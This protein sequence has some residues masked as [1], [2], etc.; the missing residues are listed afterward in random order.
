M[1]NFVTSITAKVQLFV[2]AVG[3]VVIFSQAAFAADLPK[4]D[5]LRILI[6]SDQVNPHGLPPEDL[7]QPGDISAALQMPG[8]GL[9]ISKEPDSILEIPTNSIEMATKALGVSLCSPNAYDVL[10]YFCH[11]IPNNGSAK[12][13]TA[14]QEAFVDAVENYLIA[15]GGMISFHHGS[16]KTS[17]KDSIQSIIGATAVASVVWDT[18]DGQN[19]INVSPEHFVTN[20]SVEYTDQVIY[21]DPDSGV[22]MSKYEFF[23][24]TPDERYLFFDINNDIDEF[25][26]LFASNY[27]Q[28]GTTH[29][30]GF[31]HKRPEWNGIV[32]GYQPGEYQPNALDDLDGN[33][34]Q[35]LANAIYYVS[36]FAT[37]CA[38]FNGDGIVDEADLKY[39]LNSWGQ[40]S[41]KG[42]C[43]L[44]DING[45]GTVS[46]QDLLDLLFSWGD[47]G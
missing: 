43:C 36:N 28:I 31:T 32:V 15:G 35:I 10:I 41:D 46:T 30:L 2:M 39:L 8:T 1:H 6:V 25:E 18:I 45:D 24:N 29:L 26:V 19:V 4:H 44:A 37:P 34:F 3:A 5:P 9:N 38:D 23:N 27:D 16:Y 13:N 42:E 40:C 12:D 47:C 33:N 14:R 20:N 11:R 17:G 21:S 7:T 22:P